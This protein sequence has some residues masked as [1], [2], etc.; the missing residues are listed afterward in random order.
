MGLSIFQ[1]VKVHLFYHVALIEKQV[2]FGTL[3]KQISFIVLPF[4]FGWGTIFSTLTVCL[5]RWTCSPP[6][7]AYLEVFVGHWKT[8]VLLWPSLKTF[9][10]FICYACVVGFYLMSSVFNFPFLSLQQWAAVRMIFGAKA[11]P[12]HWCRLFLLLLKDLNDTIEGIC[13]KTWQESLSSH[14]LTD[15]TLPFKAYWSWCSLS[16]SNNS[17]FWFPQGQIMRFV[18][19]G[20]T[21]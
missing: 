17:G 18:V 9:W 6:A 4:D 19:T 7:A 21:R 16:S 1:Y 13:N 12:P 8:I 15:Y 20:R 11:E 3:I 10:L 2:N 5:R 14:H